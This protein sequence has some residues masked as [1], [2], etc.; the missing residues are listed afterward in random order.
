M[1]APRE[2]YG[3]TLVELGRE[4]AGIV[5]LDAD[6]SGSTKTDKFAKAYPDRFFN[7]GIAEADMMAVAAGLAQSGKTPFASTFAVFATGRAYDQIRQSIAYPNFNVKI[8]ATHG[9]LTVG[10]DGASHQSL[11]DIALMRVLPGMTVIV[12]ADV[13]ETRAAVRAA[14]AHDGPVYIR[15]GREAVPDVLPPGA[16]FEIGKGSVLWP[17]IGREAVV[18]APAT[19]ASASLRFDVALIACGVMVKPCLDAAKELE[20]E[21]LACAVVNFASIKPLDT[22]LLLAL[23]RQSRAIV[24]AEE[25]SVIGGLGGAVCEGVAGSYPVKVRRIGVLDRF[26]ESGPAEALLA[27]YGLT[28]KDVAAAAREAL[29]R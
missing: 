29:G 15:L 26:G 3:E 23:A 2:A 27:A 28:A 4:N 16:S 7:M 14:A 8:V 12:P 21:G 1:V 22:E 17:A 13:A 11:E 20:S 6:L 25:H 10:P 24:T 18:S 19:P 5:V 9:G